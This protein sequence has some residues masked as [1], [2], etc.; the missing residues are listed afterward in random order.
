MS[1]FEP[2]LIIENPLDFKEILKSFLDDAEV[3]DGYYNA[4]LKDGSLSEH[5]NSQVCW[6]VEYRSTTYNKIGD[7]GI[8]QLLIPTL[9]EAVIII[10]AP[11]V[12]PFVI[13]EFMPQELWEIVR[14]D[15]PSKA[16]R[17]DELKCVEFSIEC[18]NTF[19]NERRRK[20]DEIYRVDLT[21]DRPV[22]YKR[23]VIPENEQ[24]KHDGLGFEDEF[25]TTLLDFVQPFPR[26]NYVKVDRPGELERIVDVVRDC[27]R[28]Q[29]GGEKQG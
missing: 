15:D 27:R 5:P 11:P 8:R 18:T 23:E 17:L 2:G 9:S 4:E 12:T 16:P 20:T 3:F 22:V 25:L 14:S 6:R 26:F 7:D 21:K 1:D 10:C 28:L 29:L 19:T 13:D 24:Q